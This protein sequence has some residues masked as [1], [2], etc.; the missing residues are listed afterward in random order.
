MAIEDDTSINSTSESAVTFLVCVC[1]L[2]NRSVTMSN[3]VTTF[4]PAV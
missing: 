2:R 1:I 3:K 4:H